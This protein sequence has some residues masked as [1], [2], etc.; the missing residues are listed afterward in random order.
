MSYE[1]DPVSISYEKPTNPTCTRW[2]AINT[3]I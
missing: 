3:T 1:I 2:L